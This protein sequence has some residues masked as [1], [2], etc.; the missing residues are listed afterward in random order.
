MDHSDITR[1]N[2]LR[3]GAAAGLTASLAM[4]ARTAI[5]ADAAPKPVAA[6][7]SI[8]K[9]RIGLIGTGNR[10]KTAHVL[11][12]K[13]TDQPMEVVAAC[14]VRENHVKMAV[15]KLGKNV[16]TYADYQKLLANPD[17]NTVIIATPNMFH[18]EIVIAAL[19]AGKHVLCEKPIATNIEEAH[20]MRAAA[21]SA[22]SQV[23]M[24]G[25]QRRFSAQ[26]ELLRKLIDEGNIG[27]PKY[28]VAVECRG[29][30]NSGDVW[31]YTDPK[32]GKPRNW[33]MF[34]RATGGT[35]NEFSCHMIDICNW[36]A[37]SLPQKVS[38][39]GGISVYNDGRD[40]WDHANAVCHHADGLQVVHSLCMFGP[41]RSDLEII[42]DEG[43][44]TS[45][46]KEI[47]LTRKNRQP[48]L[49]K[50]EIPPGEKRGK[51]GA[52]NA[53]LKLY[54]DFVECVR[55]GK[56]PLA[57]A[58]RAMATSKVCWLAEASAARGQEVKWDDLG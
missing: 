25:L 12:L 19:Q 10:M 22:P 27:K 6:P 43:S 46:S 15:D 52:D 28:L 45:S 13:A 11:A 56:K 33:R 32:T 42:G 54:K 49:E 4:A 24:F 36:L 37:G 18:K 3:A 50:I 8:D 58:E 29:D 38:G 55:T 57:D 20:A 23:L 47:V 35:L 48:S 51:G 34:Q 44:I 31:Q 1:R 14:D 41:N 30:W 40:T 26:N 39:S 7:G 5:G 2:F 53:V 21:A 9:L 16:P 17:V